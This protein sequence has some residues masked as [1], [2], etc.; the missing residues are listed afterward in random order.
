[1]TRLL[2]AGTGLIG[3]RHLAHIL[4]HP[5]LSLAGII[6]PVEDRRMMADAPGFASIEDVDIQADGILLATPTETHADLTRAAAERGW[7][8]LVEKPMAST[9]AE[10]DAMIE[11]AERAGVHLLIGHHRRHHPKVAALKKLLQQEV[12]GQIVTA[13]LM[14][15]MKKPAGYF[16]VSWRQGMNGAPV[17]QNL[18]HDIDTLRWMFGEVEEVAGLGS[19]TVRGASRT[20]SGGALLRFDSGMIVTISFADC[21]PSP[22]GFEAGTGESP[23][24]ATTREDCLFI[25]GTEGAISFPSLTVWSGA[26]DWAEAPKGRRMPFEEG[27]PLVRQLEHFADV[28]AGRATPLVSGHEGRQ[29]LAATLKIERATLPPALAG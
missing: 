5:D 4:D 14:W 20:E 23:G 27:V 1:M 7:H 8:V 10:A 9:L 26:R 24:I 29:T 22:W 28:I 16:D 12:I 11:V 3:H 21:T 15:T 2:L 19:N 17:K 25:T 18:I 13:S 6:E